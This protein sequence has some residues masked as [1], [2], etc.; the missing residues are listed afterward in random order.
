MYSIIYILIVLF[1]LDKYFSEALRTI[2]EYRY[3]KNSITSTV[4]N[5]GGEGV[6]N[7]HFFHEFKLNKFI[8]IYT[9]MKYSINSRYLYTCNFLIYTYPSILIIYKNKNNHVHVIP[10]KLTKFQCVPEKVN[11]LR[12][13]GGFIDLIEYKLLYYIIYI[14]YYIILLYL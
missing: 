8:A 13:P 7:C 14:L 11:E 9:I 6:V 3:I 5:P 12:R 4:V 1:A 2:Y 10:N